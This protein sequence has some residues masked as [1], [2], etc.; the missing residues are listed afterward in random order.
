[1]LPQYSAQYVH[2]L[3]YR[4]Y[5]RKKEKVLLYFHSCFPVSVAEYAAVLTLCFLCCVEYTTITYRL[6]Y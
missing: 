1:M 6:C 3:D 2:Y 4:V 5:G